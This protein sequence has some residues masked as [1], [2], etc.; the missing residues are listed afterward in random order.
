MDS[1]CKNDGV[2]SVGSLEYAKEQFLKWLKAKKYSQKTIDTHK[3]AISCFIKFAA[4]NKI[5]MIRDVTDQILVNYRLHLVESEYTMQSINAY[6]ASVRLMFKFAEEAG[7][8]F[9]N[10]ARVLKTPKVPRGILKVPTVD[11]IT[12]FIDAINVKDS[13]GIRNRAMI[14]T[15]YAAA[16]RLNELLSLEFDNLD[17]RNG[18]IQIVGKGSRERVLPLTDEAVKWLRKY[19]ANHREKLIKDGVFQLK[20]KNALWINGKGTKLKDYTLKHILHSLSDK[21]GLEYKM[22]VHCLRR[23]CA[24]HMLENGAHPY[25]IQTLLG[26]SDVSHLAQYL[27]M[28]II[29][30]KKTHNKS[31]L[32]K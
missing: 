28:T 22:T 23:A 15:A 21:A 30:I 19:I 8:L 1:F 20:E 24:T 32:G 27:R 12:K 25:Q 18:T 17:L 11:E 31:K 4:K 26:H 7:L 3:Y 9:V 13:N 16:L 10:P 2:I 5:F 14:E 6:I 29:E